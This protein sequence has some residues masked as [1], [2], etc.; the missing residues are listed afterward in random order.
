MK[1][2]SKSLIIFIMCCIGATSLTSC[3]NGDDNGGIDPE[4]YQQYLTSMSGIYYGSSTEWQYENKL[5]F[6]NDTIT[7]TS[8]DYM[9]KVDSITGIVASFSKDSTFA[10][11]GVPGRVLAKELPE[12]YNDLKQA[13]ENASNQTLRGSFEFYSINQYVSYFTAV[14]TSVT[15][16]DLEYGGEKHKVTIAFWYPTGGSFIYM[17]SRQS[18]IL[19]LYMA[20]VYVDDNKVYDIYTPSSTDN[21]DQIKACL[22]FT[23]SR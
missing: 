5:R 19:S 10:I 18:V 4:T 8:S 7:T 1:K 6:Y 23:V 2:I 15:Y 11:A 13:I 22:E 3:I 14:P 17:N 16:P 12:K 21:L 9:A 20:A